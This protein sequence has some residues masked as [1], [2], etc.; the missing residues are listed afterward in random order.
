MSSSG[1]GAFIQN[2]IYA[3][4]YGFKLPREFPPLGDPLPP[5]PEL[6]FIK[7]K[8]DIG[9]WIRWTEPEI[10]AR[11][12][13]ESVRLR[14]SVKLFTSKIWK[15][16]RVKE[17]RYKGKD[18]RLYG[19]LKMY[20]T[21]IFD[22]PTKGI[23]LFEGFNGYHQ[24]KIHKGPLMLSDVYEGILAVQMQTC[25]LYKH[26]PSYPYKHQLR[27]VVVSVPSNIAREVI[28]NYR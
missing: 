24:I 15:N 18:D 6:K 22:S 12:H 27:G 3:N 11:Y 20:E 7:Y 21:F 16:G 13:T 14:I 5:P 19:G 26:P 8:K 28:T 1:F 2:N 17:M 9:L 10:A 25:V 23:F 4:I